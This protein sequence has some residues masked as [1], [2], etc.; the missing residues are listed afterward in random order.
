MSLY[1]KLEFSI[2]LAHITATDGLT[3][4]E[5]IN[6]VQQA[7][8]H[9]S[10]E[11]QRV[12]QFRLN[13]LTSIENKTTAIRTY[14]MDHMKG[15]HA[16]ACI[17][18]CWKAFYFHID[19]TDDT[20]KRMKTCCIT[21]K[22]KNLVRGVFIQQQQTDDA[23]LLSEIVCFHTKWMNLMKA[24]MFV[25]R[26]KD[27]IKKNEDKEMVRVSLNEAALFIHRTI[28]VSLSS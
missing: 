11:D 2:F 26:A 3:D 8:E 18:A 16:I 12:I 4:K 22:H 23:V 1:D 14:V 17:N 6:R 15:E 5:V 21:G 10:I 25:S 28:Q 19:I 27:H 9:G 13:A 24:I 20:K 7:L